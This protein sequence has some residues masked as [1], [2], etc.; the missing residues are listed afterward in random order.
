MFKQ[1]LFPQGIPLVLK[2][3]LEKRISSVLIEHQNNFS[4]AYFVH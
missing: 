4:W 1:G 3:K 2:D